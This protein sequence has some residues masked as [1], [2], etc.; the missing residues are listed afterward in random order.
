MCSSKFGFL[1]AS[2]TMK[3]FVCIFLLSNVSSALPRQFKTS[4]LLVIRP[5]PPPALF[6]T[7]TPLSRLAL[8][9]RHL[10]ST[11]AAIRTKEMINAIT[12]IAVIIIRSRSPIMPNP[13]PMG[14]PV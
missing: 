8:G 12:I 6:I 5:L 13:P 9:C 2:V 10:K 11:I 4:N 7:C 1:S 3:A 14:L